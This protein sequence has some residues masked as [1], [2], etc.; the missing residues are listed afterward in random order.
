MKI[1]TLVL[2]IALSISIINYSYADAT[3][4]MDKLHDFMRKRAAQKAQKE[5]VQ[6][7]GEQYGNEVA[8][9]IA[10]KGAKRLAIRGV[11][12]IAFLPL[13]TAKI[14]YK[15]P[16]LTATAVAGGVGVYINTLGYAVS[17][18]ADDP[19]GLDDYLESHKEKINDF[20]EKTLNRMEL[21]PTQKSRD[22]YRNLAKLLS[23]SIDYNDDYFDNITA[24]KTEQEQND[25]ENSQSFKAIF[26]QV[27]SKADN[28]D[29]KNK[30]TCTS[31]SNLRFIEEAP[32][33]FYMKNIANPKIL[34]LTKNDN[35][36]TIYN[37]DQYSKLKNQE[38]IIESDHIPS[39]KALE[40]YF[41]NKRKILNKPVFTGSKRD[42]LIASNASAINIDYDMHL[43]GSRTNGRKNG[44]VRKINKA[45][46]DSMDLREATLKDI[47]TL[48]DY[49]ANNSNKY[50]YNALEK[51]L[52]MLYQ[53]NK[54]LCL[55]TN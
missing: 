29:K 21:S 19:S 32:P 28:Y 30:N 12:K 37:V 10:K 43:N 31:N 26:A 6:G 3:A 1:K 49:A 22:K 35:K 11:K 23:I 4:A 55:Y 46:N 5:M 45:K 17:H 41:N 50:D 2:T 39:Y 20:S 9:D 18:F 34:A 40:I 8:K 15:H 54:E 16:L 33:L 38:H 36:I 53:R 51:Q 44:T 48:L 25:V 13:S 7:L 52:F 42:K 27:K 24:S 47:S 14:A